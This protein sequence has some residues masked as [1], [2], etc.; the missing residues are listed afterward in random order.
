MDALGISTAPPRTE[1]ALTGRALELLEERLPEG[2][3]LGALL[4]EWDADVG[5]EIIAPDGTRATI[6]IEAKMAVQGRDVAGLAERFERVRRDQPA[7]VP[8]VVTRYLSP[9]TRVKLAR[10]GLGYVDATG[11]IRLESSA[12]GLF[13]SDRGADADPWR[14]PGRPR[15]T[16]KGEPAARIVRTVVDGVGPWPIRELI[17]TSG[18][19]TGST[20]RVVRFL[21]EEGLAERDANGRVVIP[22]WTHVLRR[23]AVDYGFQTSSSVTRYLAPRGF[24][25]LL[26]R[27]AQAD[28]TVRYAITGTI[29]AAEWAPYAAARLA[30]IYTSDVRRAAS[31]WD[32]RPA[33]AGANVLLA[34]PKYDVVYERARPREDGVVVAAPSQVAVDLL[35]GPG[36]NPS[37]GEELIRW[38][39]NNE[40]RW[41]G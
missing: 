23:W 4:E 18:V 34:S 37:E 14:G 10:A 25:A 16:L 7:L 15:G 32:L 1:D 26:D 9:P 24:P 27:M 31:A 3:S 12:P 13:L 11:N 6:L 20:Y 41:R 28:E 8:V 36:R 5:C 2:W 17:E 38:M 19:S 33:D 39:E 35:T 22:D 21:E 29:A 40:Q 30:T